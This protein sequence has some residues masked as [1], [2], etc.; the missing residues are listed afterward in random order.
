MSLARTRSQ[1]AGGNHASRHA[2]PVVKRLV[3]QMAGVEGARRCLLAVCPNSV[4]VVQAALRA[5]HA[6]QAPILFAA[7]LNQVDVDGGYTDWTPQTLVDF[8][9]EEADHL[10]LRTPVL[11]CLDHGGPWLKDRH[12]AEGYTYEEAITAVK[13]SLERAL[14]LATLCF[15]STLRWTLRGPSARRCRQGWSWNG[16]WS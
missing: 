8:L 5:A 1:Y 4:A 15:T 13:R 12:A 11:P 2:V 7:T 10:G 14:K 16:R 3:Y 6:A 9:A